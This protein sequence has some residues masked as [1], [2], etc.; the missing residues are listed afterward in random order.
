MH[1]FEEAEGRRARRFEDDRAAGSQ[2]RSQFP[3]THEEGEVP[4]DDLADDTDRFMDDDTHHV[5][6]EARD[7]AFFVAKDGGKVTEVVGTVRDVDVSR[8]T[9]RLAVVEGFDE[10]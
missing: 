9:N 5:F 6:I 2:G 3:S 4:G 8:F 7:A 1:Q 10:G